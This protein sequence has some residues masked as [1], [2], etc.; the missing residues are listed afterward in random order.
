MSI[1][2]ETIEY[3]V[4][5][6]ALEHHKNPE[7]S[8][9]RDKIIYALRRYVLQKDFEADLDVTGEVPVIIVKDMKFD[10]WGMGYNIKVIVKKAR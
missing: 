5:A 10:K 4:P 6:R 9:L 3:F 7:F 1:Y 2:P 8:S